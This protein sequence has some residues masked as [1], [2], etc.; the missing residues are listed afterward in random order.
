[1]FAVGGGAQSGIETNQRKRECYGNSRDRRSKRKAIHFSETQ[2]KGDGFSRCLDSNQSKYLIVAA[3]RGW[4]LF[5]EPMKRKVF[6]SNIHL[7][8]KIYH[9]TRESVFCSRFFKLCSCLFSFNKCPCF[10]GQQFSH[11]SEQIAA[12]LR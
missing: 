7:Q 8:H 2:R 5:E 4:S 11:K 9:V 6:R 10:L 3:M 1:M 12:P